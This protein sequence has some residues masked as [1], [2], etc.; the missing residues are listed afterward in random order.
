[1]V[2][3]ADLAAAVAGRPHWQPAGADGAVYT[4]PGAAVTVQVRLI[5]RPARRERHLAS[6]I[7]DG[8]AAYPMPCYTAVEAVLL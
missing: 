7:Q 4:P 8:Q 5:Q 1:M 2:T 3:D 6:I